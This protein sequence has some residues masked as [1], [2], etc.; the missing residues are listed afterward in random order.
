MPR[1]SAQKIFTVR[2][3]MHRT[4]S[5]TKIGQLKPKST[6]SKNLD[7]NQLLPSHALIKQYWPCLTY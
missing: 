5:P 1:K 2:L 6:G 4:P 3:F 7:Q